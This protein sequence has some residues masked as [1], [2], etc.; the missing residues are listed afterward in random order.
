VS[1]KSAAIA[2]GVSAAGS[3]T[4]ADARTE[5]GVTA[6][7]AAGVTKGIGAEIPGAGPGGG[8]STA[9]VG[10][11]KRVLATGVGLGM[12]LSGGA[13][14]GVGGRSPAGTQPTTAATTRPTATRR[15]S[16]WTKALSRPWV[17]S[18]NDL[19]SSSLECW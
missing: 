9:R 17:R 15:K 18:D 11:A 1:V 7:R 12:M 5:F 16:G 19:S 10:R 13:A 2:D 4:G 3:W 14:V 6:G 8:A